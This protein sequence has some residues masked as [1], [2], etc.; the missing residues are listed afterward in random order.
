[1][2]YTTIH[3]YVKKSSEALKCFRKEFP[4]IFKNDK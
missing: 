2:Q 4:T 1:M 3:V